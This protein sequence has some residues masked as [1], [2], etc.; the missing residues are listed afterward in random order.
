MASNAPLTFAIP[1][2]S[3]LAGC[4]YLAIIILGLFGEAWVRATLI[5][6]GDAQATLNKIAAAQT[7]WRAGIA[8]DL[9]MHVLDVPLIVFFYLLLK[10]VSQPLALLATVLNI[11]QT[12]VLV[13]NKLTLV[14]PLLVLDVTTTN[15]SQLSGAAQSSLVAT[16]FVA[17]KLHGH[18]FALGLVFFGLASLVRGHLIFKS[19]FLPKPLGVMLALAGGC[20]LVNSA[21]L[22]LAPSLAAAMFPTVLFPAFVG[23]LA[24]CL[25]LLFKGVDCK[26]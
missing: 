4:A 14:V 16:A 21:A 11:V 12:A 17:I 10:Q 2:Y 20:Y 9:L 18:G 24:L 26:D 23:E 25:W 1:K 15:A 8:G 7:L 5:V 13:A 3:R 19:G 22:L 6:A